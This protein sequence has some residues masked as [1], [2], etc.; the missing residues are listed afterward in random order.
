MIVKPD[1]FFGVT[2]AIEGIADSTVLMHGPDGCRKNLGAL[3]MK[4][5]PR[6]DRTVTLATPYYRGGSRIP[7]T[8][9][10]PC[11][12]IYGAYDRVSDAL[13]YIGERSP[14]F[15][16][17]V[18]SPGASLIGDDCQKAID[19]RGVSDRAIVLDADL[20]SRPINVG[21]DLTLRRVLEKLDPEPMPTEEGTAVLLGNH[22][23]QKDWES[24]NE[25]M[26]RILGLMGI[27]VIC[28]LGAGC[29]V[30]EMRRSVRAQFAISVCPEYSPECAAF[31]R[32]RCGAVAYVPDI[33]PIGFEATEEWIRGVAEATGRD[34]TDALAYVDTLRR[35]AYRRMLAARFDTD[36]FGFAVDAE[37]SIAYPLTRFLYDNLQMV[38]RSVSYNG[39]SW[40]PAEERMS[41]FLEER[42]MSDVLGADI[43]DYTEVVCTDGNT[44]DM[45]QRSNHCLR[46]VDLRF[47]SM[48][49]V[50]FLPQPLFGAAGALYILE[51]VVNRFR[52]ER[53]QLKIDG[54]E[55]GYSSVPVLKDVTLDLEGPRFVSILG[56]NGVGK[57]T[58]IHCI[59]KILQPTGGVVMIDGKDVKD[60]TVKQMAKE[61]GYVPYSANDLFPLSVIDTVLMGRHPHSRWGSLDADLGIVYDTLKMMGIEHLA[62]RSFNSLSAGQHQKVMLARGLVQDSKILLLDEPTSN[63]DVRH[64]LEVTRMLKDLTRRKGIL[65]IMISHDISITAKFA[66][67]IIL[68]HDGMIYDVGTPKEVITPENLS[69]VYGVTAKVID[70]DGRP[71]VIL[72]DAI[73]MDE[74]VPAGGSPAPSDA[75]SEQAAAA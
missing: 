1:G 6:R 55:F 24:V 26:S 43:P 71:H 73:P 65:T 54:L 40:G 22:V 28:C 14:S 75:P 62:M 5:Y 9:L 56:P 38:P 13:G 53:M 51:R 27:S 42:G 2:M 7:C 10:E 35:R 45:Y 41:R 69:V 29:T 20:S 59:N 36:T 50:E 49:N 47:P 3:T 15:V 63:L 17:V 19:E 25:E 32:D 48:M 4:V 52:G 31:Y 57:S 30:D 72:K 67:E 39:I 66:D 8:D 60:Y 68:M 34:P 33:S 16:A 64:Q 74:R 12:Y 44:A 46:G 18:C 70:D 11:D 21:I 58:L 23:L 61:V 37:P